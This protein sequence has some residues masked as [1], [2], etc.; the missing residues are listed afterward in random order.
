MH[1][2]GENTES[3]PWGHD[4]CPFS[5]MYSLYSL[6]WLDPPASAVTDDADSLLDVL[7][8]LPWSSGFTFKPNVIPFIF[9]FGCFHLIL[10]V[11][12]LLKHRRL[13][14]TFYILSSVDLCWR[15]CA[16]LFHLVRYA[17]DLF[18]CEFC[19]LNIKGPILFLPLLWAFFF[20]WL[21]L[22]WEGII[23]SSMCF[24]STF[25]VFVSH[26]ISKPRMCLHFTPLSFFCTFSILSWGS[27]CSAGLFLPAIFFFCHTMT[28]GSS[29]VRDRIWVA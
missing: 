21:D 28:F 2:L 15:L 16:N 24:I 26:D 4:P 6:G 5:N 14:L 9:I 23:F 25:D 19:F 29:Q 18:C 1:F 17:T 12:F 13:S 3:Q 20:A 11:K 22:L 8:S 7:V 10:L 27:S